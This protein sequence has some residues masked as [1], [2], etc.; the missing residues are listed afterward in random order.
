ME[1]IEKKTEK[2]FLKKINCACNSIKEIECFLHNLKK[3]KKYIYL[4]KF[5]K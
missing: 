3:T 1:N 2:S 5:L 4:Y